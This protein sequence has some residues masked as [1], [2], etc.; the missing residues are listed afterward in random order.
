MKIT[1]IFLM[2]M[3]MLEI[4]SC[5][6]PPAPVKSYYSNSQYSRL[7]YCFGMTDTVMYV[8]REKLKQRPSVQL[9]DYYESRP[10]AKL[11]IDIVNKVYAD[12]FTNAWNY[13][14]HTFDNCAQQFANV[15]DERVGLASTCEQQTLIAGVAYAYKKYNY[16]R[17]QAYKHF[18]ALKGKMPNKIVDLVYNS[19]ESRARL[20]LGIWNACM[21]RIQHE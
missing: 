12:H 17:Q 16:P 4:T 14:L 1:G 13:T 15:P 20:K 8:A 2:F 5:S 9:I 7:T 19:S 10:N 21:A 3:L 11:N 6:N 18:S